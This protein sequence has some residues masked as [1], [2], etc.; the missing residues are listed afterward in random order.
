MDIIE[1]IKQALA[2]KFVALHCWDPFNDEWTVISHP[3]D[4]IERVRQM[5]KKEGEE[6]KGTP[7][8]E[9]FRPLG[10]DAI[11][12]VHL[13]GE[14]LLCVHGNVEEVTSKINEI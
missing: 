9:Y 4:Q 6:I 14:V 7:L 12:M 8:G 10:T 5:N 11:C 13:K 2:P 3:I 1:Q